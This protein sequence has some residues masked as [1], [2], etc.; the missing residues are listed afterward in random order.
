MPKLDPVFDL[1]GLL[2]ETSPLGS[3]LAGLFGYRS[4]PSP[5][6]IVAY[7]AYLIPVLTLFLW[8]ARRPA[9]VAT[10]A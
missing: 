3:L 9:R 2:P 10:P 4:A 1:S 7:L 6:E 5:L 8:P